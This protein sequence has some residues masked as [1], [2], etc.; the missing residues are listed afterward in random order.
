[1]IK[2]PTGKT[3]QKQRNFN[4]AMAA[5]VSQVGCLTLIIILAALFGGLYLDNRF[6][7][8]PWFTLG[9]LIGSIPVSLGV[10]LYVSRAAIRKIK[11]QA[12]AQEEQEVGSQ[13]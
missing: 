5:L 11:T 4:L 6:G 9:L 8:R 13:K 12:A 7:S 1:M 3:D 2:E 10:M